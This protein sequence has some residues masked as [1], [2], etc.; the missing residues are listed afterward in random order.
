MLKIFLKNNINLLIY[1]SL[2]LSLLNLSLIINFYLFNDYNT[3]LFNLDSSINSN[4]L[5]HINTDNFVNP[6]TEKNINIEDIVNPEIETNTSEKNFKNNDKNIS[7]IEKENIFNSPWVWVSLGLFMCLGVYIYFNYGLNGDEI[8]N[9]SNSSAISSQKIIKQVISNAKDISSITQVSGSDLINLSSE[10][11]KQD[12]LGGTI[13][14][15]NDP[16]FNLIKLLMETKKT[17]LS[18][19]TEGSQEYF[20]EK[21]KF[22]HIKNAVFK[23]HLEGLNFNSVEFSNRV[24]E[25]LNSNRG[26]QQYLN[27]HG[28]DGLNIY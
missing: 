15:R 23:A 26:L 17:L 4:S 1:F 28:I 10:Q 2:S 14:F 13:N 22:T 9:S 18:Q 16:A 21:V 20:I 7:L 11:L 12:T 6:D 5:N 3:A 25:I 27:R 24:N 8:S 19:F